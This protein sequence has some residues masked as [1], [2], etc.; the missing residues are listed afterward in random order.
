MASDKT[1]ISSATTEQPELL[2]ARHLACPLPLF[3][4]R[5]DLLRRPSGARVLLWATAPATRRDLPEFCRDNDFRLLA[6]QETAE[7]PQFLIERL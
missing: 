3:L 5:R 7:G 4:L 6:V 1:V 2:D